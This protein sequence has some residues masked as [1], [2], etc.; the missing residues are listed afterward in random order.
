MCS[1]A[2]ELCEHATAD[3]AGERPLAAVRLEVDPEVTGRLEAPGAQVAVVRPLQRVL[4]LMREQVGDGAHQL[5]APCARA[6]DGTRVRLHVCA[7]RLR[8]RL[9]GVARDARQAFASPFRVLVHRL[10]VQLQGA[11][12]DVTLAA[13]LAAEG[14]LTSVHAL[15]ALQGVALVEALP[16]KLTT[17]RLLPCVY[18]DVALQVAR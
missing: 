15:V 2:A 17:V 14:L 10:L 6:R 5:V 16:A 4:L 18:A 9:G 7:K 1:Q 11:P 3:V 12:L 8:A 13:R